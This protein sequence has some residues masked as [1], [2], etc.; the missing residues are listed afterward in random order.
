MLVEITVDGCP[1]EPDIVI[2]QYQVTAQPS[3][4]KALDYSNLHRDTGCKEEDE[5]KYECQT[6]THLQIGESSCFE[7]FE[8]DGFETVEAFECPGECGQDDSLQIGLEDGAEHNSSYNHE[9]EYGIEQE[10]LELG[11]LVEY[12]PRYEVITDEP[13]VY[14]HSSH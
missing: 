6:Q 5:C 9:E 14:Q 2:P 12:C 8:E 3:L 11:I 1:V 4:D 7:I 13:I 10:S